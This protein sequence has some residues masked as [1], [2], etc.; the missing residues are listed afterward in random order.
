MEIYFEKEFNNEEGV[1]TIAEKIKSVKLKDIVSSITVNFGDK[2]LEMVVDKMAVKTL[3][4]SIETIIKR[5][6][7]K[8]FKAKLNDGVITVRAE[9]LNFKELYKLK[10]KLKETIISGIEGIAQVL[11]VKRENEYVILTSGSNLKDILN[12][13]GVNANKTT[14]NDIFE[15]G[16]ILGIEAAREAIIT[17]TKK[18]IESQGLDIDKRHLKLVA[19][20]MTVS[21]EIKGITRIGIISEKSSILARAS[22]ETPIKHFVTATIKGQRDE[23]ASV[24]ENVILNQPVPVGT[25]LP[26]LLVKVTGNLSKKQDK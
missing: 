24:I 8:N 19:D 6:E 21:G 7:E 2:K 20:A 17:E 26:G 14:T 16:Q 23:L 5:L 10:E 18:V 11:P 1:K 4:S 25:G 15:V 3:H 13:K 12:V 9:K 22:F